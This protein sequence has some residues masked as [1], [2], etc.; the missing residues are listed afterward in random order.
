MIWNITE[1]K[2][3]SFKI[4]PQILRISLSVINLI[5]SCWKQKNGKE[6]IIWWKF[7]FICVSISSF[8]VENNGQSKA[9]FQL[10]MLLIIFTPWLKINWMTGSIDVWLQNIERK[11]E[12]INHEMTFGLY[13]PCSSINNDSMTCRTNMRK[14]S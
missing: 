12:K 14:I 8:Y 7:A 6:E 9:S 10:T 4:K 1:G 3:S 13:Y 11:H 5:C 2:L